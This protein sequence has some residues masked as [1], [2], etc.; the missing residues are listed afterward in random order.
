MECLLNASPENNF[1]ERIIMPTLDS[2]FVSCILPRILC[3]SAEGTAEVCANKENTP[4]NQTSDI[5]CICRR[6]ELEE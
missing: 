2:F 1:F 5:Y 6:G 3:W 4:V